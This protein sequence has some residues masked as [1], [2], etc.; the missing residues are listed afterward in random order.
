M[1]LE[2]EM[3]LVR[4][5]RADGTVAYINPHLIRAVIVNDKLTAMIQ[6]DNDHVI[7]VREQADKVAE[8]IEAVTAAIV[9]AEG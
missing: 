7:M 1:S 4:V 9:A 8:Q 2:V 3:R 5:P 6:F